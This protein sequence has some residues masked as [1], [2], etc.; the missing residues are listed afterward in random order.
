MKETENSSV[1]TLLDSTI[2]KSIDILATLTTQVLQLIV[3]FLAIV[4][5]CKIV[6]FLTATQVNKNDEKIVEESEQCESEPKSEAKPEQVAE[7]CGWSSEALPDSDVQ[8]CS[9]EI[10]QPSTRF[11]AI[12]KHL[13]RKCISV[14]PVMLLNPNSQIVR[15]LNADEREER[16]RYDI[17][18]LEPSD[19]I[20]N[21]CVYW[22]GD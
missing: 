9:H 17:L 21:E 2:N 10:R 4:V 3:C 5:I 6:N 7:V 11:K 22:T 18:P 16:Y 12:N 1:S 15:S 20:D 14:G 13:K 19:R 8:L